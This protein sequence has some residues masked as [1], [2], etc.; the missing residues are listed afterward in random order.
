M[1]KRKWHP[2]RAM[3]IALK[4]W[5]NEEYSK[6]PDGIRNELMR[7]NAIDMYQLTVYGKELLAGILAHEAKRS[8]NA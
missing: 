2:S 8:V 5:N 4:H 1:A 7:I 3:Q 6:V